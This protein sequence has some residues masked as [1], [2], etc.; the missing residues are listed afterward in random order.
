MSVIITLFPKCFFRR[1]WTNDTL[2]EIRLQGRRTLGHLM[3]TF[4]FLKLPF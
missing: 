1:I 3:K 4:F 2:N